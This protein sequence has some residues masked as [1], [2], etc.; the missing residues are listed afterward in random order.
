MMK[1]I[2]SHKVNQEE[3][4]LIEIKRDGKVRCYKA[5]LSSYGA[6]KHCPQCATYSTLEEAKDAYEWCKNLV[7]NQ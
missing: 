2:E 4:F 5:G 6:T 7:D 1:C 3:A